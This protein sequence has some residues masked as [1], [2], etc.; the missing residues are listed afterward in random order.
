MCTCEPVCTCTHVVR[1][2]EFSQHPVITATLH[3][4][5][6]SKKSWKA[7]SQ[8]FL[9]T[10]DVPRFRHAFS[11]G[12][13]P[14]PTCPLRVDGGQEAA[15]TS[16]SSTCWGLGHLDS[17]PGQQARGGSGLLVV[18]LF[19][20]PALTVW[21]RG[22]LHQPRPSRLPHHPPFLGGLIRDSAGAT[23]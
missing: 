3:C 10:H 9:S 12:I 4:L 18:V 14:P 5:V 8:L 13:P 22:Q 11:C 2:R 19:P 6:W 21:A 15:V 20:P 1:K 23:S 17:T 16:L 7:G